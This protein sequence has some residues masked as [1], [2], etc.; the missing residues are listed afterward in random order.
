MNTLADFK[1]M[2][3]KHTK[4]NKT[5]K[6]SRINSGKIAGIVGGV[7]VVSLLLMAVFAKQFSPYDPT[8]RVGLPFEKPSAEHILGTNDIGQDILSELIY[9]SRIS[10]TI[11]IVASL[12]AMVLG[13]TV[14]LLAGY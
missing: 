6:R 13:T 11:G 8:E 9:G 3:T 14:G 4:R 5:I 12:V 7:M 1:T 2:D 10:L